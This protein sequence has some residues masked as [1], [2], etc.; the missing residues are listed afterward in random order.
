[1]PRPI[2]PVHA[3]ARRPRGNP[4]T[5]ISAIFAAAL[6]LGPA[7]ADDPTPNLR[8][9]STGPTTAKGY[10][11]PDQFIHLKD[12]KPADN[13][14]P[15]VPHPEQEQQARKKLAALEGAASE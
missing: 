2:H 3:P 5:W 10:D 13:M 8:G 9:A 4:G 6:A 7:C 15:A 14:Y 1:M 11:H 12:V